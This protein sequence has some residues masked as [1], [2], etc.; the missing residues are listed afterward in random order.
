MLCRTGGRPWACCLPWSDLGDDRKGE[1][2]A[3]GHGA[4]DEPLPGARSVHLR[5]RAP[6]EVPRSQA[7]RV[8]QMPEYVKCHGAKP[9]DERCLVQ[10]QPL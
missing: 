1:D 10:E 9:Q 8:E 2:C 7:R 4:H 5:S 3:D 6:V